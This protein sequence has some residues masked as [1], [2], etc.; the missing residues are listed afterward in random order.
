LTTA[1]ALAQAQAAGVKVALVSARPPFGMAPIAHRLGLS[2]PLIAYNGAYVVDPLSGEVLFHR[3]M[4]AGD[5]AT[6]VRLVR[7]HDLYVGYDAGWEWYV[8]RECDE[9]VFEEEWLHYNPSIVADLLRDAPPQPDKC[10]VISLS[11][12]ERLLRFYTKARAALPHLNIQYSSEVTVEVCDAGAS[13]DIALAYL[14]ERLGVSREA[15]MAIG[16]SHNDISMLKYAGVSVAVGN[17]PPDVQAAASL[18]VA[19][20]DGDGVAE[21]IRRVILGESVHTTRR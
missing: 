7:E 11:D 2:G 20:N 18:I 10:I 4:V 21:A 12:P 13:K 19:S 5:A 8:E 17:A 14:A 16:D 6:M 1:S 9:M 3:P 15:V